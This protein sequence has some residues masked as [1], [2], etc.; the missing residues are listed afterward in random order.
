M[1]AM[2][3][4]VLWRGKRCRPRNAEI[5]GGEMEI[6]HPN[7]T[8]VAVPSDNSMH[9][10][11]TQEADPFGSAS[12][13]GIRE[14]LL[15]VET[16]NCLVKLLLAAGLLRLADLLSVLVCLLESHLAVLELLAET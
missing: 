10:C 9:H 8:I 4:L 6:L 2:E 12:L 13:F 15:A 1:S 3:S 7:P 16:Y 11:R 14:I 5:R